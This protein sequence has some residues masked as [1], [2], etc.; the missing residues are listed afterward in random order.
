[1]ATTKLATLSKHGRTVQAM[2]YLPKSLPEVFNVRFATDADNVAKSCPILAEDYDGNG[3]VALKLEDIQY[4]NGPRGS[5]RY[6]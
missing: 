6:T 1:M 2:G 4:L 3:V 5:C